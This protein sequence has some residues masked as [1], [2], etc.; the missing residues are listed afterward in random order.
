MPRRLF[1]S[2][3]M[4]KLTKQ[5]LLPFKTNVNHYSRYIFSVRYIWSSFCK[6][7]IRRS[8]WSAASR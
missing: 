4:Q 3:G 2:G 5:A 8:L 7:R 1:V 6:L